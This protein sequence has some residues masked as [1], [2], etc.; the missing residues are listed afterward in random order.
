MIGRTFQYL[1]VVQAVTLLVTAGTWSR[2]WQ[3]IC[4]STVEDAAF[5]T[6]IAFAHYVVLSGLSILRAK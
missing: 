3:C 1:L 5:W 2:V 4:D 6:A